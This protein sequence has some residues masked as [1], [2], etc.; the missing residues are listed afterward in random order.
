MSLFHPRWTFPAFWWTWRVSHGAMLAFQPLV[1]PDWWPIALGLFVAME[2]WGVLRSG[3]GG[4]LS[5]T[6]WAQAR[7]E[8][9]FKLWSTGSALAYG[10]S[11][12][13]LPAWWLGIEPSIGWYFAVSGM[14]GWMIGHF[15]RLKRNT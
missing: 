6:H 15:W 12:A 13:R 2:G 9:S 1:P 10:W 14:V 8:W 5:G 3:E 7:R 11:M 4:T